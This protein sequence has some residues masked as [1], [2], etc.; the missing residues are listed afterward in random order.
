MGEQLRQYSRGLYPVGTLLEVATSLLG[1]Y[2]WW[3]ALRVAAF[4]VNPIKK[5]GFPRE[6]TQN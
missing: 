4:S 6:P 1:T 5:G 3:R 2:V